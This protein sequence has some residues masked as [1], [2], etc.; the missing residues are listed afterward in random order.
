MRDL[1]VEPQAGAKSEGGPLASQP[2]S[3]P[4]LKSKSDTATLRDLPVETQLGAK[5][6]GS[7]LEPQSR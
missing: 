3:E 1:L 6:E 4:T 5:S 7:Q 2:S